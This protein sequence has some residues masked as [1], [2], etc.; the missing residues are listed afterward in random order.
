MNKHRR[1]TPGKRARKRLKA[2]VK[3]LKA[4][5]GVLESAIIRIRGN[6]VRTGEVANI[7]TGKSLGSRLSHTY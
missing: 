4:K 3:R 6:N 7:Q 5:V 1:T 2:E